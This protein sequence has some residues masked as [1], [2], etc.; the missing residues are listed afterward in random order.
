MF[1]LMC[2]HDGKYIAFTWHDTHKLRSYVQMKG[3]VQVSI[4]IV[5]G[6]TYPLMLSY[7]AANDNNDI[8]NK[9]QQYEIND[10]TGIE[11]K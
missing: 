8:Q 11:M 6:D 3:A 7:F 10:S 4:A 5:N 2:C 1:I 9:S